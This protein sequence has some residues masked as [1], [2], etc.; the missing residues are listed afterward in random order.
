MIA[1]SNFQDVSKSQPVTH[2]DKSAASQI[3]I[4]QNK[5]HSRT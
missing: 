1:E 3:Y 4:R 2:R 5:D